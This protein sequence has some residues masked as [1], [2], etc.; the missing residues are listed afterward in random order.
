MT[1]TSGRCAICGREGISFAKVTHREQGEILLCAVCL[2]KAL[3]EG[4]LV[5]KHENGG[6]GC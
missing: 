5:P 3:Q 1:T 4:H 6:C 2:V